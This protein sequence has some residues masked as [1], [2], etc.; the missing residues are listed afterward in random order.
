MFYRSIPNNWG[1]ILVHPRE[2]RVDT[3]IHML[4]MKF[5]LGIVWI[6]EAYEVVDTAYAKKWVSMIVPKKPAR[7]VLEIVPE[8]LGEFHVGDKVSFE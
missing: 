3:S 7:F 8:R 6:N 2:N 4:F 5:D 1:L